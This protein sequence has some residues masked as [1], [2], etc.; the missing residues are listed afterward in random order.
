MPATTG[1]V[2]HDDLH[3]R[4]LRGTAGTLPF[5]GTEAS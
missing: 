1:T 2:F 4:A 5:R 3:D